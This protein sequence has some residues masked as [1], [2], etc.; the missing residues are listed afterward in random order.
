[1]QPCPNRVYTPIINVET[2][3]NVPGECSPPCPG[4]K[5]GF[6]EVPP[7]HLVCN[8]KNIFKDMKGPALLLVLG[9]P[10]CAPHHL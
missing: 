4:V 5:K 3:V 7:K 10:L 2:P 9:P 8:E 6:I 1:M